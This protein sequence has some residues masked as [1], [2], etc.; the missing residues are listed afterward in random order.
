M[1]IGGLGV[2]IAGFAGLIATLDRRPEARNPIG[3]RIPNIVIRGFHVT[4]SGFTTVAIYTITADVGMAVRIA[5]PR[6]CAGFFIPVARISIRAILA[7]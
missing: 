2:S 6:A 7:R 1:A 3:W 5:K 4:F